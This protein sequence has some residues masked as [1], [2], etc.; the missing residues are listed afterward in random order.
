VFA[1]IICRDEDLIRCSATA[2]PILHQPLVQILDRLKV[3][4]IM[5]LIAAKEDA[6][7]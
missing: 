5:V 1:L 7:Q 4:G 6:L 2:L 3:E